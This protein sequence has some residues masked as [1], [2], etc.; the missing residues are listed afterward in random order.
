MVF[1]VAHGA[2]ERVGV[3][4]GFPAGSDKALG[5]S[6]AACDSK[7]PADCTMLCPEGASLSPGVFLIITMRSAINQGKETIGRLLP[8]HSKYEFN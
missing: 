4:P 8:N 2:W 6:P 3:T 5:N 7:R 1:V